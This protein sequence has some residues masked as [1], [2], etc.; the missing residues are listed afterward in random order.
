M[1]VVLESQMSP[2][3]SSPSPSLLW[4][5]IF[6]FLLHVV[7][8]LL[9]DLCLH[10]HLCILRDLLPDLLLHVL[11]GLRWRMLAQA[12]HNA[13]EFWQGR[14]STQKAKCLLGQQGCDLR[15]G[16]IGWFRV[17]EV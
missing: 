14:I 2:H 16:T 15:T 7:G 3:K 10:V 13:V 9:F 4:D 5:L 8:G 17:Y 1:P 12:L 11:D 6:D